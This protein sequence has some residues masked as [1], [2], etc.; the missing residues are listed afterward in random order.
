MTQDRVIAAARITQALKAA[1]GAKK[2]GFNVQQVR[3]TI[4]Q[5]MAALTAGDYATAVQLADRAIDMCGG[6]GSL[7]YRGPVS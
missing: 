4:R 2:R 7:P 1:K 6:A 3:S 5:A